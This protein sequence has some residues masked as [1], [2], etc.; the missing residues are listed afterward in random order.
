[1]KK[2]RNLLLVFVIG[3]ILGIGLGINIDKDKPLLS[4][5][6]SGQSLK[7]KAKKTGG[8]VL[9]R[10]GEALEKG[11]EALEEKLKK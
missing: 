6:F 9:K 8:E 3:L 11:G 1:M 5:P 10:G 4:N 2:I 7:Q